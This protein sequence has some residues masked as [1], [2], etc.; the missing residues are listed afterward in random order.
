MEGRGG[1]CRGELVGSNNILEKGELVYQ[2]PPPCKHGS[3][4]PGSIFIKKENADPWGF[5]PQFEAPEASVISKLHY[6]PVKKRP[7]D[8]RRWRPA[9]APHFFLVNSV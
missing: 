3:N 6:G 5:E 8:D 2:F 4:S 1:Y 9:R 7:G